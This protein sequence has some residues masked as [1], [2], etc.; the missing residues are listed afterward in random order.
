MIMKIYK[1]FTLIALF[2]IFNL[3]PLFATNYYVDA[4]NGNNTNTGL[5]ETTALASIQNAA[6]LTN[7]GDNVFIMNGTY[8]EVNGN[9]KGHQCVLTIT[10][11]GSESGGYITYK[12]Y[13]GH[14]PKLS[15]LNCVW[16]CVE[17]YASY[18]KFQGMELEGTNSSITYDYAKSVFDEYLAGAR[19]WTKIGKVNI[20]G[21]VVNGVDHVYV[22][23]CTVRDFSGG[24]INFERVD[25][26]FIENN[27]VYNNAWYMMYAGS[28][29][30]L[31]HSRDVDNNTTDYKNFVRGN[32]CYNNKCLIPWA[33]G[34]QP[35]KLSDGN[36]I[37]IDNNTN[38]QLRD[39]VNKP[40]YKGR[41]L[42]ENNISYN[43]GG[44]GV[45]VYT[46]ANVDV[47]NNTAFNNGT[48]VGY[49]E[50]DAS[51][52]TNVKI[53]NN[54]MYARTGGNTNGNDNGTYNYNVYF[55]G[56]SFKR[57][58]ND[59]VADP[60]FVKL[61][62]IT[63]GIAD[64]ST[65]NF[66]LQNTSPA[67]NNGSNTAGQF[68]PIDIL[69]IARP[70]GFSTDMGAYEYPT[71]IPRT[72]IVIKQGTTE[73]V[74]NTG[75]FDFGDVASTTPKI[76]TFTIENIGDLALNLTGTP[77]VVVT[78]TGFSIETDAPAIVAAGGSATFQVKLTPTTTAGVLTGT[79]SIANDDTSENPFNF[80]ITGYGYDGTKALQNITFNE[81]P[82]KVIGDSDFEPGA[83]SSSALTVTFT[84]SKTSVA[85]I[86]PDGK[87]RLVA[88][89][90]VTITA[91]QAGDATTNMAKPVSQLLTVTPV[92]PAQ[93]VNMITNPTFD[94]DLS[95]WSFANKG[96]ATATAVAAIQPGYNGNVVKLT[97]TALGTG[98]SIDNVQY[99]TNVFLVKDR[100]YL[101]QFKGS[102][103][104]NRNISLILI[105][106]ASPYTYLLSKTAALTPS[107]FTFGEYAYTSTYTG[108]VA[109]RFFVA[110]NTIPVYIDDVSII[111]LIPTAINDLDGN[112]QVGLEVFPNPASNSLKVNYD[113][114]AGKSGRI[115]IIDLLGRIVYTKTITNNI[116]GKNTIELNLDDIQNGI[117]MVRI[118]EKN[119][120]AKTSKFIISK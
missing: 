51:S 87:I 12:N 52:C 119:G 8:T 41:T 1:K 79:I 103:D 55:N 70:V 39:P 69:E 19:D 106:N 89:G 98:S 23:N 32:I 93:G 114:F 33:S 5:S 57:G 14:K 13:P 90:T 84:S 86:T 31:F 54:I 9:S 35:Y 48:V 16:G 7:P 64:G 22:T 45:H 65:A 59:I 42:V 25:Y 81:L 11:S 61:P 56:A 38:S 71:V 26:A 102:A 49:P 17:I 27:T 110:S 43:N 94:T 28:G 105:M 60:K 96:G 10:R 120:L 85:S 37:I 101:I 3:S 118:Q 21:L 62:T 82:L 58:S 113:G 97:T 29:I 50:M 67:L 108:S 66:R 24:G 117:Y 2:V 34:S 47:I 104:A 40:P 109:F 77:K 92:L 115:E 75:T 44:G 74:D 73:I 91:S 46:C 88:A 80:A 15:A 18:I 63:A 72:E 112:K 68:S 20:N 6:N 99:S 83:T 36:G 78:G 30:S 53:Y 100:K 116:E 4:V 76:V 107:P 95:G 111:E